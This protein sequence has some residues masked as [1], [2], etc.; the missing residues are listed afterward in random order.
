MMDQSLQVPAVA[1]VNLPSLMASAQQ[2]FDSEFYECAQDIYRYIVV[3]H[4][5]EL[6]AWYG[7]GR[8]HVAQDNHA[9]AARLFE[10]AAE[11]GNRAAFLE[12]AAR[13]WARSGD[14][15]R[16]RELLSLAWEAQQ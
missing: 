3:R 7:L 5:T 1:R 8:S 10:M 9:A 13:A 2:L 11:L 6:A 14:G 15:E 16:A 4:P 12:L